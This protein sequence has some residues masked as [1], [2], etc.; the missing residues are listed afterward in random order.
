LLG[1]SKSKRDA[2]QAKPPL[3]PL[4]LSAY[5]YLVAYLPYMSYYSRSPPLLVLDE[6]HPALPEARGTNG[7]EGV[8]GV[9]VHS[10][11]KTQH[12]DSAEGGAAGGAAL[13]AV[14]QKRC[15]R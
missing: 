7:W 1:R 6:I 3:V 10:V 14:P 12:K 8:E 2:G 15:G 5:A 11:P 9:E 4:C 13:C